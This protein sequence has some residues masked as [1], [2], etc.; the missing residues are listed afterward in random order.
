MHDTQTIIYYIYIFFSLKS[1]LQK[2]EQVKW[3]PYWGRLH[4]D[5]RWQVGRSLKS[6]LYSA[7]NLVVSVFC[8]FPCS[9]NETK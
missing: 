1:F 8:Y 6:S 9:T 7:E 2:L 5:L 4:V 3:C